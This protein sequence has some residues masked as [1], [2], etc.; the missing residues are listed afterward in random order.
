MVHLA[1]VVKKSNLGVM[2]LIASAAKLSSK[3]LVCVPSIHWRYL[4]SDIPG[5]I[6]AESKRTLICSSQHVK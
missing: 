5:A 1:H 2:V 6:T 4:E 3:Q